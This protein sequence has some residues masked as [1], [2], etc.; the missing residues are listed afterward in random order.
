MEQ[1][2]N[3][4]IKYAKNMRVFHNKIK[5]QLIGKA[6][7]GPDTSLLDIGVGRGG[8][9]FKWSMNNIQYVYG[10]DPNPAYIREAQHRYNENN[11]KHNYVFST[12]LCDNGQF[13]VVSCQFAVHYM[14][15]SENALNKHLR[16]VSERLK[17]NGYYIGTF[18]NG[19]NV[20]KL[21]GDTNTYMNSAIQLSLQDNEDRFATSMNV[22]LSGT[23]YFGEKSIS[24]EY[25]VLPNVLEQKCKEHGLILVEYKSFESYNKELHFNLGKDFS[26]C[27]Y[28]YSS[29]VFQKIIT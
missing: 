29:F 3:G 17:P 25:V 20:Y 4:H 13:D 5:T 6:I 1:L 28:L 18:M 12:E 8:D 15:A 11:M 23:L 2:R 16:Y 27:S 9:M 14:F 26:V 24:S 7:R 19:D 10:Y 22:H 21:V